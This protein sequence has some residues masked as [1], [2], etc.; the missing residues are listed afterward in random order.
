MNQP[1]KLLIVEDNMDDID[2]ILLEL[3]KEGYYA[4]QYQQVQNEAEM[5]AA[6]EET[7]G[8]DVILADHELPHFNSFTALSLVKERQ[9][10][11][12]FIILS[13]TISDE[14]AVRAMK[15]GA[16]DYI[17]KN[18][19]FR[20]I[21]VIQREIKEAEMRRD[22]QKSKEKL[23]YL[24]LYDDLTELPNRNYFL[25]A[26]DQR[27]AQQQ[28]RRELFAVLFLNLNRYQM[29]KYS[30][31][32]RLGDQL[33]CATATRLKQIVKSP[34]ILAR[35]RG[36]EFIILFDHIDRSE[37]VQPI[38][39]A[40]QK[41]FSQPFN[42]DGPIV[43]SATSMG[44]VLSNNDYQTAEEFLSAAD[45]A[46]HYAQMNGRGSAVVYDASMQHKVRN[47]LQ[48]E[49]DLQ[50]AINQKKL[51]LN[52]Q[53]II[54]LET[55]KIIGFEAL[56]RWKHPT[57]GYISPIDFIPLAEETGLIIP[58]GQWT[59]IEACQRLHSWQ[60]LYPALSDFSIN[61]N[62]SGIQLANPDLIKQIDDLLA[63]VGLP[64]HNLKLEITESFLMENLIEN[65]AIANKILEELKARNIK[66]CID[67]FG[68]GY[69]SLS[70]LHYL[71]ID[72]LKI[73]RSF[74]NPKQNV[75][76]NSEIVKSIVNLAQDLGL[77]L[78]AEGI[79]TEQQLTMLKDLR[80]DYGHF[81]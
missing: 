52:Y 79:E 67:D 21:P 23:E 16:Q 2:L 1:L 8:W 62:L 19:W 58:L 34:N 18:K 33:V 71:P 43:Y 48:L 74:I 17:D 64:G 53:P 5:I 15:S 59:L 39:Q 35:M 65:P 29:V 28:Y 12:P 37:A 9:L 69:S 45:I 32:Q 4:I 61:V 44:I 41:S 11:I 6:L 57:K 13:G 63:M 22:Y 76:K 40:I 81:V 55:S 54:C 78:V 46:K 10:D 31:G 70:Y 73:D 30:L 75:H 24:S 26:L 68:T 50:D 14:Q 38:A 36:D 51:H 80:C 47:R 60:E 56:I 49:T 42:L 25:H 72:I 66:L 7:Q 27:I 3:E 20:L 77:G